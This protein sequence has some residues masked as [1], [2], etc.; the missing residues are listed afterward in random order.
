MSSIAKR[1]LFLL[2]LIPLILLSGDEKKKSTGA[3]SVEMD[4]H[5]V[6]RVLQGG[7]PM[8]VVILSTKKKERYLMVFVGPNEAEAI[9][10]ETAGIKPPRPMTHDL[11]KNTISKFGGKVKDITITKLED[12]IFYAEIA[13]KTKSSIVT[14]DARPSDSMALAVRVKAPIFV[15]KK[16]LEEA[17]HTQSPEAIPAPGKEEKPTKKKPKKLQFPADAI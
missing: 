5:N 7:S 9:V 10:R 6:A 16:V 8:A 13:V 11:L 2:L 4:I 14:I 15:N 3:N 17:G 12:G 1:I